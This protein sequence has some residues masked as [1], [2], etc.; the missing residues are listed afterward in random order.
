MQAF[1]FG[2]NLLKE[3]FFHI[4]WSTIISYSLIVLLAARPEWRM[5]GVII[6]MNTGAVLLAFMHYLTICKKIGVSFFMRGL[7]QKTTEQKY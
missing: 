2:L 1:L 4:I 5:N 6:G 7:I 3:T